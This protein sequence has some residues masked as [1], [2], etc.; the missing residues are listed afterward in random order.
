[1]ALGRNGEAEVSSDNMAGGQEDDQEPIWFIGYDI[2]EL[3][4]AS[5]Q[6]NDLGSNGN[7]TSQ[8]Y[9]DKLLY[10]INNFAYGEEG[11][12]ITEKLGRCVILCVFDNSTEFDQYINDNNLSALV[13]AQIEEMQVDDISVHSPNQHMH[14]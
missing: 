10:I 12:K 4:H 7:A 14:G 8:I 3:I 1:M 13:V 6:E 2:T 5:N 9:N 11:E